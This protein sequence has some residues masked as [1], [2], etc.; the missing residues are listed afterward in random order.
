M[1]NAVARPFSGFEPTPQG[2]LTRASFDPVRCDCTP[3]VSPLRHRLVAEWLCTHSHN[4]KPVNISITWDGCPGSRP[5]LSAMYKP[6]LSWLFLTGFL[7]LLPSPDYEVVFVVCQLWQS[8]LIV[9]GKCGLCGEPP[10]INY[11]GWLHTIEWPTMLF[12]WLPHWCT[13]ETG[14]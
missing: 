13:I 5:G 2:A 12:K 7:L 11:N 1:K 10:P 14:I 8:F 4:P 3:L 6:C 9:D